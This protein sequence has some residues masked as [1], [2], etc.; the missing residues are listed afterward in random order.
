MEGRKKFKLAIFTSPGH[1]GMGILVERKLDQFF[2]FD[3]IESVDQIKALST[4][5]AYEA[6]FIMVA[7]S[8]I[9]LS[10]VPAMVDA[11]ILK[12][13]KL[14]WIHGMMAGVD[15]LLTE[16]LR[17]SKHIT[18]TNA[19]G[20]YDSSL[21]ESILLTILYFAKRVDK[22]VAQ[23]ARH[24]YQPQ[25]VQHAHGAKVA[26][27]G[28]GSIGKETAII[29]KKSLNCALYAIRRTDKSDPDDK[30]L[31]TFH[32]LEKDLPYVL[33]QADYIINILPLTPTTA[34]YFD[35]AMFKRMRPS[36]IY[37]NVGRGA[38]TVEQDLVVA[39]RTGVIAGAGLDVFEVEPLPA[40]SPLY[41]LDNVLIT[42]HSMGASCDYWERCIT[43]FEK[44]LTNYLSG[45]PFAY[46]VD[47][48]T[49]Y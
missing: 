30:E 48:Q 49:G 16:T 44:E 39:L 9:P 23:K 24:V 19:R 31:L 12:S 11:L 14:N 20:A 18:L 46:I 33:S 34:K 5:T 28:Y 32:G 41:D 36:A 43:S 27:I 13:P 25:I 4:P 15:F 37:I 26:I 35:L 38:T 7:A 6:C 10:T 8:K 47:V 21:S 22:F 3:I 17:K 29:L 40:T 2:D 42:A 45:K 1:K